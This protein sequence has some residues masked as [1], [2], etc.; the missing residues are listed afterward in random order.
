[1]KSIRELFVIGHGPSSSHTMGPAFACEHILKTYPNIK[2]VD[3]TLFGSLALTGK[4]HLTDKIIKI[5]LGNYLRELKFDFTSTVNHP[6]TMKFIIT[7]D[8]DEIKEETILSIGGGSIVID[9][10]ILSISREIYPH[11]SLKE[12][13]DYCKEENISLDKY[14]KRFEGEDILNYLGDIYDAIERSRSRGIKAKG[15]LPGPLKVQ[16]KARKM[17]LNMR[18]NKEDKDNVL[19]NVSISSFA[20]S[21]EN[22]SGGEIVIAPTC[23][24]SGVLPG[25][26]T[27]L[28]MKNY[29][30]KDIINGLCVAGLIGMIAKTN[31]SISGAE[32][33]CQAEIGVACAMSAAMISSLISENIDNIAISAE[34]AMEHS[35]GLTCDPVE[36]YVQIPCIERCAIFAMKAISAASLA[37]IMP[38]NESKVSFDQS[39]MTMYKTGR[40]LNEGY[41]ETGISGLADTLKR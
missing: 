36:G 5:K 19:M 22:A 32:C 9:D 40:D 13:I 24:S 37:E 31:A 6:N 2:Y 39:L 23:G 11:K 27:Y 7:L 1:M 4:G 38:I 12:I 17:Y 28:K 15:V 26:I 41:R 34:I 16:R 33:G 30:R 18:K 29:S 25:A 14:V 8:N 35:L 20:V 3:V 10:K 21:E